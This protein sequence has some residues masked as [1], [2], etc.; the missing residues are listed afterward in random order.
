MTNI[1]IIFSLF[2]FSCL[3]IDKTEENGELD[4]S[5]YGSPD[6]QGSWH[7]DSYIRSE[8]KKSTKSKTEKKT[9]RGNHAGL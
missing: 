7:E 9:K 6:V 2:F 3:L 5:E 8:R 1:D 4:D